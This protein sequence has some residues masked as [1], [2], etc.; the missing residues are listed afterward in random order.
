MYFRIMENDKVSNIAVQT[1]CLKSL[2]GISTWS[3]ARLQNGHLGLGFL[4][5]NSQLKQR[6]QK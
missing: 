4:D 2:P 5:G 3:G 6:N 1:N